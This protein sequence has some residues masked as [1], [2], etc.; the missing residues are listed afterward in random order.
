[1]A[2]KCKVAYEPNLTVIRL[3]GPIDEHVSEILADLRP[4]VKT[5]HVI[6]DCEHI[7][8]I[9]SI[10]AANWIAHIR[11]YGDHEL[12]F[13]KCP[14]VFTSLCLMMPDLTGD[15]QLDSLY[16]RYYCPACEEELNDQL[17][18][19]ND[20][21]RDDFPARTCP[22]CQ[23]AMAVDPEDEDFRDLLTNTD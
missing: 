17:I 9:N 18:G 11:G 8:F 5:P 23:A 16:V 19:R 12:N 10:G 3:T 2:L 4:Q 15:G 21:Q 6:F 14:A 20:I 1:M 7:T 13:I 22:R